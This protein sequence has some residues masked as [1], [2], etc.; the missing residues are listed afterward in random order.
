MPEVEAGVT[1]PPDA[2]STPPPIDAG[3]PIG[4]DAQDA[5]TVDAGVLDV[6]VTRPPPQNGD[7][8]GGRASTSGGCSASGALDDR[9]PVALV[10][11]LALGGLR[12]RRA[13]SP[14]D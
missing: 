1:P 9:A 13:R 5:P 2:G 8:G 6:P 14:A 11:L 3:V 7:R 12:R 4:A 10:F